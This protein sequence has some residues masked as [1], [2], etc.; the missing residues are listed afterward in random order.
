VSEPIEVCVDEL[1]IRVRDYRRRPNGVTIAIA[2]VEWD[3][4]L[5]E[6]RDVSLLSHQDRRALAEFASRRVSKATV[7]ADIFEQY[8]QQALNEAWERMNQGSNLATSLPEVS[9]SDREI[10]AGELQREALERKRRGETLLEFLPLLGREG[11]IARLL[12]TLISSYHKV[13]KTHLLQCIVQ[14]WPEEIVLWLTEEARSIWDVRLAAAP[15]GAL[16][17]VTLVYAIGLGAEGMLRRIV[18]GAETVI[19]IDTLRNLMGLED[20][21]NNAQVA[22]ALVPFVGLCAQQ[23]KTL[24]VTH[25]DRKS[26]GEHGREV[27]GAGAFIGAVDAVLTIARDPTKR[28]RRIIKGLARNFAPEDLM[29]ERM[30]DGTMVAVGSPAEVQLPEVKSKV[31]GALAGEWLATTAVWEALPEPRPSKDQVRRALMELA[32]ERLGDDGA[33][34]TP[35]VERDPPVAVTDVQGKR[36]RWRRLTSDG[37]SEGERPNLTSALSTSLSEVSSLDTIPNLTSDGP[38]PKEVPSEVEPRT[39]DE[40]SDRTSDE[41]SDRTSDAIALPSNGNKPDTSELEAYWERCRPRCRHCGR[42]TACVFPSEWA[43]APTVC[44]ECAEEFEE[45]SG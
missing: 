8:L 7:N 4:E 24:I 3:G 39:S 1:T 35:Q 26:G 23:H 36:L 27:A 2:E 10:N 16:D 38:P 17:H 34:A 45:I 40:T 31:L 13:G 42:W 19:I 20:E 11:Y 5:L 28:T 43:K 12:A 18:D 15:V 21:S 9:S 30:A 37:V 25:V 32:L 44:R 41:T 29:Y 22:L 14:E 6:R 33:V